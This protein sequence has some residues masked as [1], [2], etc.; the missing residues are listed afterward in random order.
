MSPC[1][2]E[3]IAAAVARAL[4]QLEALRDELYRHP[5][6]GGE[7]TFASSRLTEVLEENG[8]QV[9]REYGGIPHAFRAAASAPVSGPTVALFAEYDALPDLGHACGH[10][11][12]CTA[13]LG[14]AWP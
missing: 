5:E 7:E 8:F 14:A 13:A 3:R 11:L 4:P 2:N 9:T 12:I 6:I 10:N 1:V